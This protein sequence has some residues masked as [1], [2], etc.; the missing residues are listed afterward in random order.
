M[1]PSSNKPNNDLTLAITEA[2]LREFLQGGNVTSARCDVC[3]ELIVLEWLS[4]TA[5][6]IKCSCGKFHG[7]L[8]GILGKEG[9]AGEG[10]R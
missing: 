8:R 1:E 10:G 5:L 7:A 6:S 3:G 2:A 9:G 4:P